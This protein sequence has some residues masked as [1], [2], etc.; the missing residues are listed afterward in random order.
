MG[1]RSPV[2]TDMVITDAFITDTVI[3]CQSPTWVSPTQSSHMCG[4][5]VM[6]RISTRLRSSLSSAKKGRGTNVV[7]D[8]TPIQ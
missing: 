5:D 7:V 6:A 3:T 4:M 1:I 2:I 8:I